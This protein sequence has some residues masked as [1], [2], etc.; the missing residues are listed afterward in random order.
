M[1]IR[2]INMRYIADKKAKFWGDIH[3]D[4]FQPIAHIFLMDAGYQV[5]V[6][7]L[8]PDKFQQRDA[9]IL[10]NLQ[11]AYKK[12]FTNAWRAFSLDEEIEIEEIID[13]FEEYI[14]PNINTAKIAIM[15]IDNSRPMEEQIIYGALFA[16]N[17]L[18]SQANAAH[19]GCYVAPKRRYDIVTKPLNDY[20]ISHVMGFTKQ[21]A[22][23]AM[24]NEEIADRKYAR[25]Q[26]EM[27]ALENK[28][29]LWLRDAYQAEMDRIM[30]IPEEKLPKL[31][32]LPSGQR[33]PKKEEPKV[34]IPPMAL[35]MAG[36]GIG[37]APKTFATPQIR[38]SWKRR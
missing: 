14:A 4:S 36:K 24:L 2:E 22:E 3:M 28:V 16:C 13:K 30:A 1:T 11:D 31:N 25:I 38:S 23:H 7:T 32:V 19:R 20:Y 34:D 37:I 21:Y 18:A 27:N 33:K 8:N 6:K 15:E 29:V 35:L 26:R 10:G 5:F 12:F 9:Q 17:F